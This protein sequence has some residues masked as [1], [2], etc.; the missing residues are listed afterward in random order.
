MTWRKENERH[1][2]RFSIW[3][4]MSVKSEKNFKNLQFVNLNKEIVNIFLK[5]LENLISTG[6][7]KPLE[8]LINTG[9]NV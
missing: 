2:Q 3:I 8:N 7:V 9:K 6:K 1:I 4:H 5:P